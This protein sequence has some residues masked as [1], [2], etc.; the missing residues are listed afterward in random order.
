[1]IAII[2]FLASLLLII[3]GYRKESLLAFIALATDGMGFSVGDFLIA[4]ISVKPI[5]LSIGYIMLSF[6][7][8]VTQ[9]NRKEFQSAYPPQTRYW[10]WWGTYLVCLI[11]IDI[12]ASNTSIFDVYRV[13]RQWLLIVVFFQFSKFPVEELRWVLK[14]LMICTAV[15]LLLFTLQPVFG[16]EL[17]ENAIRKSE[18]SIDAV[19]YIN[20]PTLWPVLLWLIVYSSETPKTIKT[21]YITAIILVIVTTTISRSYLLTIFIGFLGGLSLHESTKKKVYGFV[22]SLIAFALILC[23]PTVRDRMGVAI[24]EMSSLE[25]IEW[26]TGGFNEGNMIFRAAHFL[27]RATFLT[28]TLHTSLFGIGFIHESSLKNPLF[29]VGLVNEDGNVVQLDTGDIA[30]SLILVRFG[31]I[32]IGFVILVNIVMIRFF[33]IHRTSYLGKVGFVYGLSTFVTSLAYPQMAQASYYL[34]PTA[35][36]TIIFKSTKARE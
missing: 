7:L 18:G 17:T 14:A 29:I 4:G 25:N 34:I 1:M 10:L 6:Y 22:A 5:D 8:I 36:M 15:Q 20:V 27:E 9:R 19:R 3:G 35:M 2:L 31:F 23:I 13:L 32:G 24:Q 28:E 33:Y 21:A 16:F 12:I 30:W 11:I 26:N